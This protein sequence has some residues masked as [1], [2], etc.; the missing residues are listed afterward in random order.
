M[1]YIGGSAPQ[2]QELPPIFEAIA[3]DVFADVD[4]GVARGKL[5]KVALVASVPKLVHALSSV[6]IDR[7]AFEPRLPDRAALR[8]SI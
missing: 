3:L 7:R 4:Q 6:A 2:R 5:R 8:Y 1:L